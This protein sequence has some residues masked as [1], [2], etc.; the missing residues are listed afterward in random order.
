M[1]IVTLKIYM[2]KI[3]VADSRREGVGI[4]DAN[5]S[6]TY[7]CAHEKRALMANCSQ[8]YFTFM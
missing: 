4:S 6:V 2:L 3:P 7:D 1:M 8:C 5:I